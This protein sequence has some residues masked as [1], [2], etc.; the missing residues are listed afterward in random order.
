VAKGALQGWHPDPFGL[1]ELRY[2]SVGNPTKLVRDGGAESYDEPPPGPV[3]AAA[4]VAATVGSPSAVTAGPLRQGGPELAGVTRVAASAARVL[5]A[6]PGNAPGGA[7]STGAR[8]F[9]P[10]KRRWVE[11]T[12]V[13][14]GAIVAVLVFVALTSGSRPPG[15]A[16]AAFV[17]KAAQR[18]LNQRSAEVTLSGTVRL[19]GQTLAMGGNG[20]VDLATNSMSLD[21]GA[22]LPNGSMTE[23]E[24]LVGGNIY[25][26]MRS[27]G[28]NLVAAAAGG[29]HWLEVPFAQSGPRT[30]TTGSPAASL[31]LLSQQGGRVT[32]LGPR[33]IGGRTCD[34]YIVTPSSQAILAGAKAEY[35]KLGLSEA[36][37]SA[38]LK[39]LQAATPPT[40]TA[41]FDSRHQLACQV[42][43]YLQVGAPTTSSG[44]VGV[45][46][47]MTF[48]H[49]GA[50]VSVNAPTAADTLTLQQFLKAAT[51]SGR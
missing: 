42:D 10:R 29:R 21:L 28:R 9:A 48:T 17:T 18:T 49:Y 34:G 39:A 40:I 35:A 16:P 14:A 8:P 23:T 31:S 41:W 1:H 3:P 27:D 24:L 5:P 33:S 2:F 43:V 19:A 32:S 38:A 45:Q 12:F 20:E 15:I 13:A 22:S 50:P 47:V 4:S 51:S 7:Y 26:Q 37:T 30:L 11:Y 46:M 44:S 6:G 36:Q 25:L